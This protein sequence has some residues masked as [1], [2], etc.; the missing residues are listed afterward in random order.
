MRAIWNG[1][2]IAQAEHTLVVE[3]NHYFPPET[4]HRR[5]FSES[6][7][8]SLCP[9]KGVARYYTVTVDGLQNQKAAWY[10]AQPPRNPRRMRRPCSS[11]TLW[12]YWRQ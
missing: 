7:S 6:G 3:G 5:Y 11:R 4:L 9:W 12:A 1:T 8:R 10:T 2:V